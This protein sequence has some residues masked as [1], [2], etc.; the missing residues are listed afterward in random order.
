MS[1]SVY[2]YRPARIPGPELEDMQIWAAGGW[3][4]RVSFRIASR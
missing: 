3:S 2:A 4:L 1:D